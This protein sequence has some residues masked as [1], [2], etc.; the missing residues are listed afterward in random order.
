MKVTVEYE[1]KP[2]RCETCRS[3]GHKCHHQGLET[4]REGKREPRDI[5]K[6][7]ERPMQR[8]GKQIARDVS[9]MSVPLLEPCLIK[10]QDNTI[11]Q[12]TPNK[13]MS[14]RS[15]QSG[16]GTEGLNRD[17]E[18][19]HDK[20]LDNTNPPQPPDGWNSKRISV[21]AVHKATQWI[22]CD[23]KGLEDDNAF[24]VTFVYGL[25]TPT[26]RAAIW[27]YL[28]TEKTHNISVPWG[29]MGDFNAIMS[30]MDRQGGD[31]NWYSHMEDYP[32]CVSQAELIHLPATGMHYTW[33]NGRMGDAT[34]LK[35]LD[36]SGGNSSGLF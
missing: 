4:A 25:N 36:C 33:H 5:L 32:N 30:S 23:I 3:F 29:I 14:E 28:I 16:A 20:M 7:E 1:W 9:P 15:R 22:T 31:S 11:K 10:Q 17:T 24:R 2:G 26:E 8:E 35:K 34:I 18:F 13:Q 27:S 12:P 21:T 19:R 6:R